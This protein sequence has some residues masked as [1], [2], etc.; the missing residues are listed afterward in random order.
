MPRGPEGEW[1]PADPIVNAVHVAK[2]RAGLIEET[3]KPPADRRRPKPLDAAA[4]G[5]ARASKMTPER[6]LRQREAGL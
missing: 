6:T 4:G 2:I 5:P 1:R 3:Y